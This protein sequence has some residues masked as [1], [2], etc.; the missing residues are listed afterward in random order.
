MRRNVL[1]LSVVLLLGHAFALST[2]AQPDISIFDEDDSIGTGYYDA[3]FG[4]AFRPSTLRLGGPG[5]KLIIL[6]NRAFTG[7]QSGLLQWHSAPDGSWS[8]VVARQGF[9]TANAEG[10]SNLVLHVNSPLPIHASHLPAISLESSPPDRRTRAIPL[11]KYLSDG[12]DS[13]LNTWQPITIPLSAFKATPDFSLRKVK[14]VI[15]SQNTADHASG[16]MWID[17]IRIVAEE[18]APTN[19]NPPLAPVRLVTRA[20]DQS[21]VLQWEPGSDEHVV[22]YHVY[23]RTPPSETLTKLTAAPV[24]IQSFADVNVTNGQAYKYTIRAVNSAQQ[25][26]PESAIVS[27][28]PVPF[29]SQDEFLEYVQHTAFDYFWYQ[30]NPSNGLVRDRSDPLSP[31]SI[32]AVGFGLSG[33]GIAIDRGWI[34]RGQGAARALLTLRTLWELPQG[35]NLTGTA[36]YKGWFYHFLDLTSGTR[37][38]TS[39]L[40]S[41]DTAL[42]LAGVLDAKQ[43][44]N[45]S[46]T[47]ELTIQALANAIVNRVDWNWMANDSTS[48]SHGWRPESGFITARWI[49]YNEGMLLYLLGMGAATN[50][51][52]ADHWATWTSGYH[53]RTNYGQAFVH[54]PPLFGHQY[55]HCWIDFRHTADPYMRGKGLTYFENSR[56][57]TLAQREYAIA[58]PRGFTGYSGELWGLTASDGPGIAPYFAYVARGT[59]APL[60]DDGTIAPT[61][62]GGS[63][64]FAPEFALPTLRAMYDRFRTKLWT[65][66]GFRD[67]FNL[68]AN[69][70]GPHVIGIDQGPILLMAENLRSGRVWQRFMRNPEIQRGLEAAGFTATH[71]VSSNALNTLRS[72]D[73]RTFQFP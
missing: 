70:W 65:G 37:A 34:T 16:T 45:H 6:T 69:W 15:F 22:G 49:G 43:F 55:S 56:R 36:G 61:A 39:E 17:D 27:A 30:A 31:C 60:S 46:N 29:R 20:G 63:L 62:V 50:P 28:T 4:A 32:A 52:S 11:G 58:N 40:S 72:A 57:A 13:D 51:L 12:V 64:P 44:F 2:L 19:S 48:L 5:D 10:Y 1:A 24:P 14:D 23:R 53:W 35:P 66:Y 68:E 26:S 42:M 47:N 38:G 73:Y 59:P 9:Q 67:A 7:V 25:E 3:S 21:I 41:I 71:P 8:I 18:S 54:F 33:I